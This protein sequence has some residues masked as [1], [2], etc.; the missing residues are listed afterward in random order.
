MS[1]AETFQSITAG[2]QSIV[3]ALGLAVTGWWTFQTFGGTEQV[4]PIV[5]VSVKAEALRAGPRARYLHVTVIVVNRGKSQANLSVD[6]SR[7]LLVAH[8]ASAG[9][10]VG[11]KVVGEAGII[12]AAPEGGE[13]VELL[14]INLLPSASKTYSFLVPIELPGIY[15]VSFSVPKSDQPST[16]WT[17]ATYVEVNDEKDRT[18]ITSDALS[19]NSK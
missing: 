2:V 14:T 5:D 17:G 12:A 8:V 6:K 4:G 1:R 7:P 19:R 9:K 3:L 11:Y 15:F 16:V 18:R 13:V 10:S